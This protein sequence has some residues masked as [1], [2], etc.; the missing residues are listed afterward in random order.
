MAPHNDRREEFAW[1]AK[2][3]A[4]YAGQW[5]ALDGKRLVA[6]GPELVEVNAAQPA[7]QAWTN[8]C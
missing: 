8:L 4:P 2:E 3:S 6:H 1:L 7:R 5:I